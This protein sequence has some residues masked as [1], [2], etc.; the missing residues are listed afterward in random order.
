MLR[1]YLCAY[2]DASIV[3]K[4]TIE[5]LATAGNKNYKAEKMFRLKIMRHLD[6]VFQKLT[7]YC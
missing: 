5:L 6:H 7:V 3:V 4:S 1:L 2:S